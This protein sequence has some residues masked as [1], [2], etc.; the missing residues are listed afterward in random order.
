MFFEGRNL[1]LDILLLIYEGIL[2]PTLH[3]SISPRTFVLRRWPR[4]WNSVPSI[5]PVS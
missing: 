3:P 5:F 2:T 4:W 1:A